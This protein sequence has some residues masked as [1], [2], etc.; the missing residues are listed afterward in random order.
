MDENQIQKLTEYYHQKYPNKQT[1]RIADTKEITDGW[2]T[3]LYKYSINYFLNDKPASEQHVIRVF[4]DNAA[5]TSEKEFHVM[6]KLRDNG[7]SVPAVFH[8]DI[9]GAIIGKPFI[10]MEYLS[11]NTMDYRFRCVSDS[12]R[13]ELYKQ[14]IE[15][16]VDLHKVGVSKIFPEIKLT[17]TEDYLSFFLNMIDGRIAE[18]K[19]GWVNPVV[20]WL[21][22]RRDDVKVREL[23]VLHGDFHGRNILYREDGSPAVIDWSGIH[24]GDYRFDLAWTLILFSTFGGSF[25]RELLMNLYSDVSGEEITD[26]EFFEVLGCLVRL[27]HVFP[28]FLKKDD[29]TGVVSKSEV[30]TPDISD[31]FLKVYDM[32][33]SRTG[34]KLPEFERIVS[35]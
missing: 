16:F 5:S 13:E 8:N 19:L 20:D 3:K 26:I 28:S 4:S 35:S 17:D 25:F 23:S 31:H 24:V 29:V 9:N 11:G 21:R 30:M 18:S 14:M 33:V 6:M 22:E 15:L 34:I 2:E 10:I 7:Y 27:V 12:E 32:L 1:L